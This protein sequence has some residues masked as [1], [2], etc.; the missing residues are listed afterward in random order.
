M[1][2]FYQLYAEISTLTGETAPV[3]KVKE[4]SSIDSI[5]IFEKVTKIPLHISHIAQLILMDTPGKYGQF[6]Q[7]CMAQQPA[8]FME[9][10][11]VM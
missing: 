5:I 8:S 7:Q 4:I 2:K 10:K 9:E 11:V 1:S 6:L 3:E